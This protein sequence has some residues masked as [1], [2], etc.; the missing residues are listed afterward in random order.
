MACHRCVCVRACVR[1]CARVGVGAC[2][3]A[4]VFHP[5]LSAEHQGQQQSAQQAA[6][7]HA[8]PVLVLPLLLAQV[9][10]MD[11][12]HHEHNPEGITVEM[13][14]NIRCGCVLTCVSAERPGQVTATNSLQPAPS[15][16]L[17]LL[18]VVHTTQLRRVPLVPR[19]RQPDWKCDEHDEGLT[20]RAV[21]SLQ[22]G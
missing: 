22:G 10:G 2:V 19:G 14:G 13:H 17:L 16:L 21:L 4:C 20:P 5:R 18:L 3:R 9:V 1:A 12:W 6:A 15:R 11:T 8:T 7:R